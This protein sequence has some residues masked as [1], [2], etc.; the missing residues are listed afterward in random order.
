M[1]HQ[2][3]TPGTYI[4]YLSIYSST[5][6]TR[7]PQ[8][9]IYRSAW[10]RP[11][12]SITAFLSRSD[13]LAIMSCKRWCRVERT[14]RS[15]RENTSTGGDCDYLLNTWHKYSHTRVPHQTWTNK[16][17]QSREG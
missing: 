5:V 15:R 12:Q 2:E 7:N 3:Y 9:P 16:S 1:M 14:M 10:P 8:T 13:S 11:P 17:G 6:A 4:F